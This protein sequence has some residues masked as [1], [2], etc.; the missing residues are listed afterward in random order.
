MD[1]EEVKGVMEQAEEEEAVEKEEGEEEE[2][3]GEAEGE[4]VDVGWRRS[5]SG[6]DAWNLPS[7]SPSS[8]HL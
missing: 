6:R 1:E 5:S 4:A 8:S 7:T 2:E 3:E